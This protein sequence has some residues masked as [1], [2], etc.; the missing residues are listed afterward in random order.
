MGLGRSAHAALIAR[1]FAEMTRLGVKLGGRAETL[2]GLCGLGDLVLTCSSSQS[3]NMSFGLEAE[4]R[5]QAELDA[6]VARHIGEGPEGPPA[7]GAGLDELREQA[8]SMPPPQRPQ[9]RNEPKIGRNDLCP[10]GSGQKFKK[11]HGALLEDD[12][13]AEAEAEGPQPRA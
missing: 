3:R 5:H 11:C 12:D 10:C 13:E 9:V 1:G 8:A 4:A 7:P 6:A 2:A